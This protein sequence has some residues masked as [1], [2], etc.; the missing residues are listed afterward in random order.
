MSF[1]D[2][3]V[4]VKTGQKMELELQPLK[5][6]SWSKQWNTQMDCERN[7]DM[8]KELRTIYIGQNFE[9]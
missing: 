5:G 6:N 8:L 1:T 7:E 4:E 3:Y 2:M 9:V